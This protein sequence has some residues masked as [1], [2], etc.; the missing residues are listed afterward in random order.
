MM[1]SVAEIQQSDVSR[2]SFRGM[3]LAILIISGL[4]I[5]LL[6]GWLVFQ[7]QGF[8]LVCFH[9]PAT[10]VWVEGLGLIHDYSFTHDFLFPLITNRFRQQ[11]VPIH[12]E[13]WSLMGFLLGIALFPGVGT[14]GCSIAFLATPVWRRIQHQMPARQP[15][16][17]LVLPPRD[18]G[19]SD[20]E[21]QPLVDVVRSGDIQ[22][23]R[24]VVEVLGRQATPDTIAFLRNLLHHPSAD[25]QSESAL[26]LNRLEEQFTDQLQAAHKAFKSSPN[27]SERLYDVAMA[28]TVYA[29]SNLLEPEMKLLFLC[30]SR[31]YFLQFLDLVPDRVDVQVELARV[32]H[33]L[34]ARDEA[35]SMLR[36]SMSSMTPTANDYLLALDIAFAARSWD[37]L[38]DWI[39]AACKKYPDHPDIISVASVWLT[40]TTQ[41]EVH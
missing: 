34:G 3:F 27:E 15:L 36:T 6:C 5:D 8:W 9:M 7:E 33:H 12:F 1:S 20:V 37:L 23:Q 38:R 4:G 19:V 16:S 35:L 10:I 13:Y 32:Y 18:E 17:V 39:E 31:D 28:Y 11:K 26:A 24:A 14:L 2:I 29:M 40:D 41:E 25:V 22:M 30:E 21:L